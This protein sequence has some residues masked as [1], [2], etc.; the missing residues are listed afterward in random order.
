MVKRISMLFSGD[1][2]EG[3]MRQPTLVPGTNEQWSYDPVV[4]GRIFFVR[5]GAAPTRI[6]R[7]DPTLRSLRL[8]RYSV[9]DHFVDTTA[10]AERLADV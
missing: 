10:F 8:T 7:L 3:S 2:A 4:P 1:S 9:E 6:D 5:P